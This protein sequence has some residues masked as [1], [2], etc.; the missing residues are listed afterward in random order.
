[1]TMTTEEVK[2][3]TLPATFEDAWAGVADV[4]GWLTRGQ[5]EALFNG[6]RQAP[7]GAIVEIG[8]HHGRSTIMLAKGAMPGTRIYAIDP[9]MDTRWGGGEAALT[10]FK[11]NIADAGVDAMI[12]SIRGLS[13][14]ARK[15]WDGGP[16]A[17][18]YIDGAHDLDSVLKDIDDW[19]PLVVEGGLVFIHDAFSSIGVTRAI[20]K[21]HATNRN[22]KYLG[23]VRSLAKFRRET[24]SLS[25]AALNGARLGGRLTYF[26]RNLAVKVARRRDWVWVQ[27]ALCHHD[28]VDPY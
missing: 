9:Y 25:G 11:R 12:T 28:P 13:H 19:E 10:T 20:M 1:M 5:A 27:R 24:L 18:L 16:I 2:P 3:A 6:A 4:E 8:S 7:R 22:F 21:R 17:L 15:N 14:E 26:G 23:A